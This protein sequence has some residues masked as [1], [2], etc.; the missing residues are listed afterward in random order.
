MIWKLIERNMDRFDR[1]G[2]NDDIG[3]K[4]LGRRWCKSEMFHVRKRNEDEF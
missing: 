2:P 4:R 3:T 1:S